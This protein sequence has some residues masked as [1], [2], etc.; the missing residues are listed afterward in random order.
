[1]TNR[2]GKTMFSVVL[3]LPETS[4][5]NLGEISRLMDSVLN[6][7]LAVQGIVILNH[8]KNGMPEFEMKSSKMTVIDYDN[9]NMAIAL[10]KCI[11]TITSSHVI[12]IDN[13][14]A[15]VE[16]KRS[17]LEVA[18]IIIHKYTNF[19]MLYSDYD[20]IENGNKKEIRLLKHHH[21]R[22][23]DNQDY[24]RVHLFSMEALA[25]IGN[26]DE[27]V[28]YNLMYDTRLKLSE[29]YE[30]VHIANKYSGSLYS[31][32]AQGKKH[33]VFD[34]L[35]AGKD[36]QMEA[37][38]ILTDHLKRIG[39]YLEPN[40]NHHKRPDFD[41]KYDLAASV[42]IPVNN[43]PEFMES[44][45]TSVFNQTEK[46]IEVIVVVNGGIQDPTVKEVNKYLPG[47]IY[48]NESNPP[49]R[50]V[51][52][53]IN[54]IGVSLNLGIKQARGQYYIQL[55][56]DDRLKPNAVE[57]AVAL[58]ESDPEIGI[59]IG[60][61]EVWQKKDNGEFVR[62]EEI[63]V[64]THDE[65]TDD[66]GRNNLFHINGAGAPRCIPVSII[67]EMGYFGINDEPYA[68][69]YGEDYDLVM[70]ISE[71]YKVGRIYDPIYE[72][73]RHSGGTDH[74]ID[75]VT[76]DRNDEAKDYMRLLAIQRRIQLC[77]N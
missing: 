62:M 70:K 55:D 4:D 74:S 5:G 73:V 45:L 25:G 42:V 68:R 53:D 9:E 50:L 76:I 33:N 63:P 15:D 56:S 10:N 19:G 58:F 36:V 13:T 47:G 24:G 64:V 32:V 75:Q 69:N 57:K 72:V 27:S 60:S 3:H 16:L 8:P 44:A 46:E 41:K 30:I 22:L 67:K 49:V 77:H 11:D 43:R 2:Q 26:F 54:N 31:V 51:V 65:W 35:L 34:Y 1:M 37:E 17:F 23:R 40:F 48:F 12:Y 29:K 6:Q 61:Y 7:G 20:L 28:K 59:V 66:N 18:D 39:A 52:S 21:G 71:I 14:E 38:R